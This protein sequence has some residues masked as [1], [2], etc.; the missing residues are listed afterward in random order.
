MVSGRIIPQMV[1]VP[2]PQNDSRNA[3]SQFTLGNSMLREKYGPGTRRSV[4]PGSFYICGG[5]TTL[6][7]LAVSLLG[8]RQMK[9]VPA[10]RYTLSPAPSL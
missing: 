2:G 4:V 7:S 5:V 1:P 10:A 9:G 8:L 3:A 6:I